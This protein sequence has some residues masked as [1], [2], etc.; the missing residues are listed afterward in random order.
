MD[1]YAFGGTMSSYVNGSTVDKYKFTAKERDSETGLDYFGARYYDSKIG[2]WMSVDPLAEKYPGLSPY[3]YCADNPL[4]Y[5]DPDGRK[6]VFAEG[7][8]E[9][10]KSDFNK[11]VNYLKE[12]NALGPLGDV[13]NSDKYTVTL[14]ESITKNSAYNPSANTIN[15]NTHQGILTTN[16]V[17]ESPA[18]VLN[19][20]ADHAKQNNT[21]PDQYKS[22]R[23]LD[24]NNQY[25]SA[26][27]K[28]VITGTEQDTAEKLGEVK[29]GEAVRKDHAGTPY[30]T[31]D[32]TSIKS[33]Y[34]K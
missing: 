3:N 11:T 1:Y 19:H 34:E 32:P 2:R 22:D 24:A 28:R 10:F 29:K 23:K 15:W 20:E 4:I 6:I 14:E 25:D 16:G 17:V 8:S 5:F 33:P 12:H 7:S 30:Y 9:K 27:E 21:N 26:E 31:K 13:I 18:T